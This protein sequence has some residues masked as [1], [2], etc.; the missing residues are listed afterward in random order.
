MPV[1]EPPWIVKL[2]PE[3]RQCLGLVQ[4][5]FAVKIEPKETTLGHFII[6]MSL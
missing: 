5:Q 3:T 6:T 1:R 4:E 2:V